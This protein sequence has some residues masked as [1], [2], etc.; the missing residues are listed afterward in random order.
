MEIDKSFV[1]CSKDK[2]GTIYADW[3]DGDFR[4][5]IMRGPDSLCAYIGVPK[6]HP[7]YGKGYNDINIECH[8]GLTFSEPA[9]DKWP[10]GFW[11]FGWDYAHFGDAAFYDL[12]HGGIGSADLPWEPSCVKQQFTDVIKQFRNAK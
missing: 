2:P 12:D 8:G 6:G 10:D 5:L 11:W 3:T 9:H 4:C 1:E 7:F